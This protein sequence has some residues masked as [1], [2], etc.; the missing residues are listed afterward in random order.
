LTKSDAHTASRVA[1]AQSIGPVVSPPPEHLRRDP[2]HEHAAVGHDQEVRD[3][4]AFGHHAHA[5][6]VDLAGH[7]AVAAGLDD[8]ARFQVLPD[9]G[10]DLLQVLGRSACHGFMIPCGLCMVRA[11]AGR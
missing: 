2:E 11:I 9:R 6:E 4:R 7:P 3:E 1:W 5:Q 8:L 10:Q